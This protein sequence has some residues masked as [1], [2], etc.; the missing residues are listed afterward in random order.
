MWPP[1]SSSVIAVAALVLG[2]AACAPSL[3]RT[4]A[5][6]EVSRPAEPPALTPVAWAEM[7]GW[8]ADRAAQLLPALA[9]QCAMQRQPP[10]EPTAAVPADRLGTAEWWRATCAAV[11]ALRPRTD[12]A[13]RAFIE[14]HFQPVS[15]DAT[16]L[17]TGYF[18]PVYP[19][20]PEPLPGCATPVRARPPGVVDVDI[21]RIDPAHPP[22][23]LRGCVDRGALSPCPA[24][25]AIEAGALPEAPVLAWMDPVDKF[26]MQIQG[27]GR[28]ALAGN[29]TMRLGY[30]AQ[31]GA[32][33]VPIGRVLL[34]RGE[35]ARP[36]SMQSIRAW[37]AANPDRVEELLNTNPSYV[38]FRPLDLPPAAGPVGSLGVPLTAGRSIAVDP[39][40]VPLGLP[41]FLAAEGRAP[42][43]TMAQDT[44]GAIRGAGRIDLFTGTGAA[45]GETAGR[46]V[47]PVRTWLLLPVLG[48]EAPAR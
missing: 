29:V 30:E 47:A 3:E 33:Y 4:E 10:G 13:V 6:T 19:A 39:R 18:E 7:P 11:A 23:R 42:L 35:I 27:S 17:L 38:F 34:E 36:V 5:P 24:R 26:F 15:V 22:R 21:R 31:N 20:C 45:A 44:G 43:L 1:R 8:Q 12:A 40:I 37:L 46:L 41:V 14:R 32:P 48:E 25:A 16:G 9:S 28:L 2:L